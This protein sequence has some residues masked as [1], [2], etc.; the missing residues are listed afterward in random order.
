MDQQIGRPVLIEFFD[1]CRVN[2]LRT[3]PYMQAWHQRYHEHGLRVIGVHS[4]GFEP[5]RSEQAT[6]EAVERLGIE[7]PV[8]IDSQMEV[9]HAY[10][11]EGWPSRYLFDQRGMLHEFHFGEGDYRE[12]ELAIQRLLGVELEPLPPIRAEDDP[13]AMLVAQTAD[14]PGV[15]SGPYEAGSVWGVLDGE[16][17]LGVNGQQL[18][19]KHPG[20]YP[21]IEH[22]HHIKGTLELKLGE[23]ITCHAICFSPGLAEQGE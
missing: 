22:P 20:C 5:S 13:Q 11:C 10:G 6:R 12:T 9:W 23:G 1:F 8:V 15:Y 17:T 16:G 19:I 14:K 21:L 7:Y 2:S 4:A 3:L 18:T